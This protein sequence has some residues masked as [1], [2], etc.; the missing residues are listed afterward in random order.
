MTYG[1]KGNAYGRIYLTYFVYGRKR[2]THG[3]KDFKIV[4]RIFHIL[5]TGVRGILTTVRVSGQDTYGRIHNPHGRKESSSSDQN[6][7]F[8]GFAKRVIKQ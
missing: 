6:S 3:R 2:L 5:L 1:R 4:L 7:K 8:A